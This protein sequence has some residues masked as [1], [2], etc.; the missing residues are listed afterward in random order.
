MIY[1]HNEDKKV[2]FSFADGTVVDNGV[3]VK[4]LLNKDKIAKDWQCVCMNK[5]RMNV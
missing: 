3:K 2:D 1:V 5:C 4:D